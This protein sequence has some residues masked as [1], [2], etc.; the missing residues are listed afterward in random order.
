MAVLKK[1][2]EANNPLME[3]CKSK[4]AAHRRGRGEKKLFCDTIQLY[5]IDF[6]LWYF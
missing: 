1:I 3:K 5:L 6:G 2:P 4:N